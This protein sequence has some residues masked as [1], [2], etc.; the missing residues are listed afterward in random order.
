MEKAAF[1]L[2]SYH[3]TKASLDFEIPSN[4]T[5]GI[6]FNPK[7]VYS[8]K[9]GV[10]TLSFETSVSCDAIGKEIANVHCIAEFCFENPLPYTEI[11]DFFYPNCLAIVFPYIRA[12]VGTLSLQANKKPIVLPTV[13]LSGLTETLKSQTE[14]KD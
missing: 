4:V 7:G 13:N 8:P 5:M 11:P 2:V 3:F 12:F 9:E 14:V 1:R 10:Y 6:R